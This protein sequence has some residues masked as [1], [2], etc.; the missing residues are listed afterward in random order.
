MA[1]SCVKCGSANLRFIEHK[2]TGQKL[3]RCGDCGTWQVNITDHGFDLPWLGDFVCKVNQMVTYYLKN[4]GRY[5]SGDLARAISENV[6]LFFDYAAILRDSTHPKEVSRGFREALSILANLIEHEEELYGLAQ[7][8]VFAPPKEL[9]Y[10][11]LEDL[12]QILYSALRVRV[13]RS[14]GFGSL[15]QY[16]ASDLAEYLE[17]RAMALLKSDPCSEK[18][19]E[20]LGFLISV[21]PYTNMWRNEVLAELAICHGLVS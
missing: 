19:R 10:K 11:I 6:S 18:F 13:A 21:N 15:G 3:P 4:T 8:G 12:V 5:R 9:V 20:V 16:L 2:D 14:S 17:K 1:W 7:K